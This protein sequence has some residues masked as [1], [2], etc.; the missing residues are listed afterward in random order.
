MGKV[1]AVARA[2]AAQRYMNI[3]GANS[4]ALGKPAWV[5]CVPDALTAIEAMRNPTE[6]M[7]FSARMHH[8]GQAYLPHSVFNAM[9]D[10]ALSEDKEQ[11]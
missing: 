8:E 1:E 10:A 11:G 2:L 5:F 9:I 7:V 4:T 3:G 6:A